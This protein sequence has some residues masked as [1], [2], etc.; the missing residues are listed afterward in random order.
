MT[1]LLIATWN[2]GKRRELQ[3]LLSDLPFALMSLDDILGLEP[4]LETGGTFLENASLKASGYAIQSGLLT[5]ADDSGLEVD[6]LGGA[7]GV[8]SARYAGDGASDRQ[9]VEKLLGDLRNVDE[10]DRTARFVSAVA[11]AS[12]NGS[13]INMSVGR[14]EGRIAFEPRGSGGFGYD[15]IFIP[16]GSEM[17]FAEL[18]PEIKNQISHRHT[19]LEK[20]RE[21][22]RNL[23]CDSAAR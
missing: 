17:T 18:P 11:T 14:C 9:R 7:P 8:L 23:T 13:I 21:F 22:L 5:L 16:A 15:P 19:A 4:V 20:A 10:P 3:Q 6:A 1:P 2:K 12:S